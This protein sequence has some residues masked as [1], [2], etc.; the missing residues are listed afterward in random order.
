[1]SRRSVWQRCRAP[2]RGTSS[3]TLKRSASFKKAFGYTGRLLSCSVAQ[4]S[5]KRLAFTGQERSWELDARHGC[6]S[7]VAGVGRDGVG[8]TEW[9]R[10]V[11][12]VLDLSCP[13]ARGWLGNPAPS[14]ADSA[15]VCRWNIFLLPTPC[16]TSLTV[17]CLC[18][19][20]PSFDWVVVV[21][22]LMLVLVVLSANTFQTAQKVLQEY[23]K[24]RL[25]YV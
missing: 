25:V 1:M 7:H 13:L 21:S 15:T 10:R 9:R 8:S 22:M 2:R 24:C 17:F 23:A 18:N 19:N 11:G 6:S 14:A 12:P 16:L 3:E 4:Q 5:E 20:H